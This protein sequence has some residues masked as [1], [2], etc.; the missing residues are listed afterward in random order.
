M[1]NGGAAMKTGTVKEDQDQ[2][3]PYRTESGDARA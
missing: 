2:G 3:A 1:P